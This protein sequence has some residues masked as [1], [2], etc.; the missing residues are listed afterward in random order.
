MY[1][2]AWT[3]RGLESGLAS[4]RRRGLFFEQVASPS[5]RFQMVNFGMPSAIAG[6]ASGWSQEIAPLL[7]AAAPRTYQQHGPGIERTL[8]SRPAPALRSFGL[9]P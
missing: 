7:G 6:T 1:R 4:E 3:R 8:S 9:L 2:R 5:P